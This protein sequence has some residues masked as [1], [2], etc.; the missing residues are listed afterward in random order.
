[1]RFVS[2]EELAEEADV[3]AVALPSN[4]GTRNVV[5]A[6]LVARMKPEAVFVSISRAE[7]MDVEALIRKAVENRSFYTCLDLDP[8]DRIRELSAG[9]ENVVVTP[10]IAGGTRE[11]RIRMFQEASQRIAEYYKGLQS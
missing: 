2:L 6:E 1:M 7:T 11:N 3:I 4:E 10:H 5:S 9:L 8:D